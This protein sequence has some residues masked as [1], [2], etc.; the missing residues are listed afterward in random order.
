MS[1]TGHIGFDRIDR[2]DGIIHRHRITPDPEV[3]GMA[4]S[5]GQTGPK[6]QTGLPWTRW[7]YIQTLEFTG[8][9]IGTGLG[10]ISRT[11][12]NRKVESAGRSA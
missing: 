8:P 3:N 10:R 11:D 7:G 9:R 2:P 1:S 12:R 4:G 5:P 6:E